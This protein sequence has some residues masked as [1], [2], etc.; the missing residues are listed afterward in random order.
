MADVNSPFLFALILIVLG[1]VLKRTNLLNERDGEGIAKLLINVTLPALIL[2]TITSIE[3]EPALVHLPVI[4]LVYC[5]TLVLLPLFFFRK[6]NRALRGNLTLCSV[7][8]SIGLFAYPLIEGIFGA[9]GLKN[10]AMFDIGNGC[11]NFG[12]YYIITIKFS[13]T[14]TQVD[15]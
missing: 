12:L 13:P 9:E 15:V 1:Y 11:I 10:I 14:E 5:F 2:N 8:F 3:I 7:G 4:A 6:K